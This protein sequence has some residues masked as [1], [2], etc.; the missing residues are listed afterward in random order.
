MTGPLVSVVMAVH[1][2]ERFLAEAIDSVLG[3]T[4]AHHEIVLVDDGSM[5]GSAAIARSRPVRYCRQPNRGVAAARN[6]GLA[7]ARG[8]LIAFLDQDDTWLPHKLEAQVAFLQEHPSVDIVL[9]PVE[10][11]LEPGAPP[12][13]WYEPG[14]GMDVQLVPLLGSLLAR[15]SAAERIGEFDTRYEIA[16]DTDWFMRA[17]DAG[18]VVETAPGVCMR[19]R[20][21]E[22]NASRNEE[23]LN[24]EV[25][26]VY[27]A[28]VARKRQG[29]PPRVGAP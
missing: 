20:I 11:Q 6:A 25:R 17:R 2:G 28:S 7:A 27:R 13:S 16:S 22:G 10:V 4:Y 1:D 14:A 5:D 3:Q 24:E 19:Y 23:L 15:R 21:H 12:L 8:E 18:L 9:S 29:P 26:A